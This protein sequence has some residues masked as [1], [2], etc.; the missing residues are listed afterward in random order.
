MMIDTPPLLQ[1]LG[2]AWGR[3]DE[4]VFG[5]L[6]FSVASAALA[7]VEGDNGSGKTTLLRVLA[8][9]L[10]MQE[11]VLRW[12]GAIFDRDACAGEIV[13]LGHRLG[14]KGD[15]SALEN[16][17]FA[18]SVC[19]TRAGTDAAEALAAAGLSGF[20]HEPV[21]Q[22]SAGQQKRVALARLGL[23]PAALWLLD[24]PYANLDARGI[25]LVNRLLDAHLGGG[26][27]AVLTSHGP[28]SFRTDV[29]MRIRMHA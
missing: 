4:P 12:R 25:A 11:G 5:P 19:G 3:R 24:E 18:A 15:L 20:E 22:L 21:R 17:R 14:L 8:G 10:R 27:A 16:L 29:H 26:G 28:L 7:V 13:L 23:L 9:L 1:A 6:D 2:L